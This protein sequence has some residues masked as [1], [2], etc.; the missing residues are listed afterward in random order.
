MTTTF[1][2]IDVLDRV[3]ALGTYLDGQADLADELG[4]LPDETAQRLRDAGVM[5]MLQPH[6]FAGY[7]C[8]PPEWFDA[9]FEVGRHSGAVTWVCGVVGV[10]PFELALGTRQL[11]SEIWGE[12][13]D[14]WIA[15]PYAPFGR[16]RPV[17]GGYRFTGRWP[18]STG[19]YHCD[20][21]VLGGLITDQ[22]GKA[23]P[24][25]VGT[26]HFFLPKSDY[27]T[28]PDEWR[29]AG[30]SGTGSYDVVVDDVFIP[31]HRVIDPR[32]LESGAAAERAG[33]SDVAL[34]R[35]PFNLM[36]AGTIAA[37][38]LSIAR[39]GLEAFVHYSRTRQTRM[40]HS[41][42]K[43]P[44]QLATLGA[45]AADIDAGVVQFRRDIERVWALVEAGQPIPVDLKIEVRRNQVRSV[46][47]AISALDELMR[48]AG[49]AAM[50]RDNPLQRF[51][52]D[53]HTGAGHGANV[54]ET[55]YTA[56]GL[57]LFGHSLPP[58]YRI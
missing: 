31:D 54:A 27:V 42:S 30:L 11:Q 47:R 12:D 25:D 6:D 40:N 1:S 46:Q 56:Y 39:G 45:A 24:H 53:A 34:Y 13:P 52:R 17:E 7:Q 48:H 55:Q 18:W 22:D 49:G 51:W 19:T 14:V 33:R 50:S 16:A 23:L 32:D 38:A 4:H 28:R 41:V 8:S 9:V 10:H 3:R 2:T 58:G 26:R 36:F 29:M 21:S 5:R 35:F 15:S 44:H 20:W 37:G 57:N 43:D